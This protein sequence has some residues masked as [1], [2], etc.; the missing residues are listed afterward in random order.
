M[1]SCSNPDN[2]SELFRAQGCFFG[3]L[4]GD[5]LGSLIEF[6]SPEE[7]RCSYPGDVRELADYGT[8][9]TIAGQATDDSEMVLLV[10]ILTERSIHDAEAIISQ[11]YQRALKA[12]WSMGVQGESEVSH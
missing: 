7:T 10:R 5:A 1:N 8:W 2:R 6:Q 3:Q 11:G 12:L 9:N 4:L